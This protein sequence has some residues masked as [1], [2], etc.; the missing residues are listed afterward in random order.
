MCSPFLYKVCQFTSSQLFGEENSKSK[1]KIIMKIRFTKFIIKIYNWDENLAA[2]FPKY[3]LVE[4]TD[5]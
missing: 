1:W 5:S 4:T 3:D 2:Y